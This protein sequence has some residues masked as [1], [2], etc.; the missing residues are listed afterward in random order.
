MGICISYQ[1]QLREPELVP[2]F[3]DDISER[4]RR[5]GWQVTTMPEF[6]ATAELARPGLVGISVHPHPRCEWLHFHFDGEG[7][8]TN[9]VYHGL[10]VDPQLRADF[11]GACASSS[12][13]T[14]AEEASEPPKRQEQEADDADGLGYFREGSRYNRVKTQFAGPEVHVAVCALIR[15]IVDTYAPDLTVRDDS[16]YYERGNDARLAGEIG[17]VDQIVA[18]IK[19]SVKEL[20]EAQHGPLTVDDVVDHIATDVTNRRSKLH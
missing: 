16:Q 13:L 10:L 20:N 3:I 18:V 1:G 11:L 17:Q 4:A 9:Y 14:G 6:L 2:R 12:R 15:Y 7:R 5:L 19:Q 8:F